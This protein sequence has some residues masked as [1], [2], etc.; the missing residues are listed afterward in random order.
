MENDFLSQ[1]QI[2]EVNRYEPTEEDLEA[3]YALKE[4]EVEEALEYGYEEVLKEAEER[5]KYLTERF[6]YE[7]ENPPDDYPFD[8]PTDALYFEEMHSPTDLYEPPQPWEE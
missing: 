4:E 5:E 2:E 8:D 7:Y 3:L 6:L 1:R